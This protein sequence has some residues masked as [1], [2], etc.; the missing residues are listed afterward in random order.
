[1]S[2]YST[3]WLIARVTASGSCHSEQGPDFVPAGGRQDI[4][5]TMILL[6]G[7]TG[8]TGQAAASR[9]A[10]SRHR[11]R[12][13]TRDAAR[14]PEMH[15]ASEAHIRA[16][17][18]AWTLVKPNFYMQTLLAAANG[19]RARGELIIPVGAARISMVDCRADGA[20]HEALLAAQGFRGFVQCRN[21]LKRNQP[22]AGIPAAYQPRFRSRCCSSGP[23]PSTES[24]MPLVRSACQ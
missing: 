4:R 12:V 9:P 7:A 23:K 13:V 19:I 18:L 3:G 24:R 15:A 22:L 11:A 2:G 20:N 10:D 6:T 1:M 17:G 21:G 5:R 14:V 8:K 16:S